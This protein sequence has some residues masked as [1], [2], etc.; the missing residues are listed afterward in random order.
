MKQHISF[1]RISIF[2]GGET[3]I[4]GRGKTVMRRIEN[5]T[6]RQ[7]TFSKRRNGL[8]KKASEL[9]V[10]CDGE[11]ALIV[12]SST[13]KLYEFCSTTSMQ[14]TIERYQK[15]NKEVQEN[16]QQ[17]KYEAVNLAKEIENLQT[18]QRKLMGE[19][20][21]SC[22]LD[23]LQT[24]ETQLEMS[25]LNIRTKKN[26]LYRE[27]IEQLKQQ[28]DQLLEENEVLWEKRSGITHFYVENK[29]L[30]LR[31]I[32]IQRSMYLIDYNFDDVLA[33]KPH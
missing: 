30:E 18:S 32:M 12:F 19:S 23:E 10:L 20:L 9:S 31:N 8:L 17:L 22:S 5:T 3:T 29:S 24:A 1:F 16:S 4:M 7:V 2:F 26:Q 6:S 11:I 14:K 13:G 27:Q 25:L 28:E 21:E 33:A 15:Y